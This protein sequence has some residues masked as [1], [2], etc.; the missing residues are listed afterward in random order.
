MAYSLCR[1]LYGRSTYIILMG[2]SQLHAS[3]DSQEQGPDRSHWFVGCRRIEIV[4][5]Y[6]SVVTK[7]LDWPVFIECVCVNIFI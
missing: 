1:V 5:N 2:M 7:F 4:Y 6:L 3:C